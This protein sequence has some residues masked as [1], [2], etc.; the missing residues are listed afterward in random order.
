VALHRSEKQ[1]LAHSRLSAAMQG[2]L[3]L[4]SDGTVTALSVGGQLC[5]ASP[6][7]EQS[8][9]W[10]LLPGATL[11]TAASAIPCLSTP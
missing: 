10:L 11:P 1:H 8:K 9:Q 7:G 4:G 6:S 3:H 5:S 2:P